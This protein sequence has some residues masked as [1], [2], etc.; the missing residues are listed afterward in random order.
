MKKL[1]TVADFAAGFMLVSMFV[2]TGWWSLRELKLP[3]TQT[4]F[5]ALVASQP[6]HTSSGYGMACVVSPT[7]AYSAYHMFTSDPPSDRAQSPGRFWKLTTKNEKEDLATLD[8]WF[9]PQVPG[10]V[11]I[12]KE[13]PQPGD[14]VYY[15]IYI[16]MKNRVLL[17]MIVGRFIAV[18]ND[19]D[20]L[21]DGDG[22]FG[23]SGGCVLNSKGELIGINKAIMKFDDRAQALVVAAN[24][25]KGAQAQN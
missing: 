13:Y 6:I 10:T 25:V 12:A 20:I 3:Q 1:N 24:L 2:L 21:I 19:G 23:M 18:D 16:G 11:Q 14:N 17:G 7:R 9:G 8:L 22:Q 4:P 5:Q 15:L